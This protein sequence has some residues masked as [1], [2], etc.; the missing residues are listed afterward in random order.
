ET[1]C[2][3]S[4]FKTRSRA[5]PH[6]CDA[7][8]RYAIGSMEWR[9]VARNRADPRSF[10]SVPFG[11]GGLLGGRGQA[12]I[13]R[14]VFLLRPVFRDTPLR[15]PPFSKT[16]RRTYAHCLGSRYIAPSRSIRTSE[17]WSGRQPGVSLNFK[18]QRPDARALSNSRAATCR[19]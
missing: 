11:G 15:D 14:T 5:R 16:R 10:S 17:K 2:G 12:S 19:V 7:R 8:R 9:R 4:N 6:R 3:R 18:Q 1:P 13:L